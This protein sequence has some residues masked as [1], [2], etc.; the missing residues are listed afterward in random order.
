MGEWT[1]KIPINE[2]PPGLNQRSHWSVRQRITKDV[3]PFAALCCREVSV[4]HW[5]PATAQRDVLVD[6][7]WPIS[8]R[9]LPD[10][11]NLAGRTKAVLDGIVDAGLLLNDNAKGIRMLAYAQEK[12]PAVRLGV[13][14]YVTVTEIGEQP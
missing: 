14:V 2:L 1:V 7:H 4:G 11:D 5:S 3:R 10:W 12:D 9:N 8:K 13:V 6:V